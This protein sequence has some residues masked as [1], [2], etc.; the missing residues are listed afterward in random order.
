MKGTFTFTAKTYPKCD[1]YLR[2]RWKDED[3]KKIEDFISI[4]PE[5]EESELDECMVNYRG[6]EKTYRAFID[7]Y[8]TY[9]DE[10]NFVEFNP[11]KIIVNQSI[12]ASK[13]F[14][15]KTIDCLQTARFFAMK[16]NLVLLYACPDFLAISKGLAKTKRFKK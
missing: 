8:S 12:R 4:H 13:Y 15:E 11:C 16:S 3:Y 2:I 5:A 6:V 9:A 1:E 10:L 14:V 7:D